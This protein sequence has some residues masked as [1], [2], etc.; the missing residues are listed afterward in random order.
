MKLYYTR[1]WEAEI[2]DKDILNECRPFFDVS[3][4]SL[5][6]TKKDYIINI[7]SARIISKYTSY[8]YSKLPR[9]FVQPLKTQIKQY[10]ES[11]SIM[12]EL[13]KKEN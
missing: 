13:I 8:D 7:I 10:L 12:I 11:F 2:S 4:P 5:F 3:F 1:T 9:A 6:K